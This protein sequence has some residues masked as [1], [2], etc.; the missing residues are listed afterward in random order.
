MKEKNATLW[1]PAKQFETENRK[2]FISQWRLGH[3]QWQGLCAAVCVVNE[4]VWSKWSA[5]R[6]QNDFATLSFDKRTI[7]DSRESIWFSCLGTSWVTSTWILGNMVLGS[8]QHFLPKITAECTLYIGRHIVR[9]SAGLQ[10]QK[11]TVTTSGGQDWDV[12]SV[13]L[14]TTEK[15]TVWG[16]N[17]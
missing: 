17:T 7:S 15:S 4:R 11:K 2:L 12:P 9:T 8:K 5:D 10:M 3:F 6:I 16:I 13:S 14:N 1:A